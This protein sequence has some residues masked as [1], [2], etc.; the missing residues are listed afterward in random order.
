M[1]FWQ[2]E[3]TRA[4]VGFMRRAAGSNIYERSLLEMIEQFAGGDDINS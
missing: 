4:I 1:N 2:P 3:S